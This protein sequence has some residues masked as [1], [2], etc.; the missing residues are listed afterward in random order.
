MESDEG[1]GEGV[2]APRP[3]RRTMA[4]GAGVSGHRGGAPWSERNLGT[5]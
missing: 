4:A 3:L 2:L 1:A 5:Y